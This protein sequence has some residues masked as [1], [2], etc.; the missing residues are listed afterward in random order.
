MYLLLYEDEIRS[1]K[2]GFLARFLLGGQEAATR[3][4]PEGTAPLSTSRSLDKRHDNSLRHDLLQPPLPPHGSNN[5]LAAA[6]GMMS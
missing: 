6:Q 1:V 2:V 5:L 3:G 4:G